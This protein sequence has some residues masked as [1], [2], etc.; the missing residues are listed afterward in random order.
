MA[1]INTT[2]NDDI[3]MATA[4]IALSLRDASPG[5]RQQ[6]YYDMAESLRDA[7]MRGTRELDGVPFKFTHGSAEAALIR[8][9]DTGQA[10]DDMSFTEPVL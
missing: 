4:E 7:I 1:Q 3:D 2:G 6:E 8:G 9:D 5:Q 10:A